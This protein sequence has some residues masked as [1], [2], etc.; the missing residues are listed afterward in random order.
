MV[1]IMD[2]FKNRKWFGGAL[3]AIIA[4][5]SIS[6]MPDVAYSATADEEARS[7]IN[8]IV[9]A[10]IRIDPSDNPEYAHMWFKQI[11]GE[12]IFAPWS[13]SIKKNDVT[14]LS[15]AVGF[16][17]ILA[18]ILGVVIVYYVMIGGAL[19]TAHHGEVLGK[20]WSSVWIPIRTATGFFLIMPVALGGKVLSF[21]Q[22]F[23]IW[24]IM[25][26]SNSATLLWNKTIDSILNGDPISSPNI[27]VGMQP[28]A[29]VAKMLMCTELYIRN[30]TIGKYDVDTNS[31][32]LIVAT[33]YKGYVGDHLRSESKNMEVGAY[34]IGNVNIAGALK[35]PAVQKISFAD[36]GDCGSISFA[37]KG[38]E[39]DFATSDETD[40]DYKTKAMM[41]GYQAARERTASLIDKLQPLI[42]RIGAN[43]DITALYN[44]RQEELSTSELY[45]SYQLEAARFK[46]ISNQFSKNIVNDIHSK[47]SGNP[48]MKN[49]WK[50][51][52]A[53]GGWGK[54][55]LWFFELGAIPGMTYSVYN[56]YIGSIKSGNPTMC[57]SIA[58]FFGDSEECARKNAE[59][60]HAYSNIDGFIS[61]SMRNHTSGSSSTMSAEDR[62]N[63]SSNM[64]EE[65]KIRA[66]DDPSKC[67]LNSDTMNSMTDSFSMDILK[68]L[69]EKNNIGN[70]SSMASPFQTVASIGHSLNVFTTV[71][72][73][74]GMVSNGMLESAQAAKNS[75][76]GKAA[77]V[78]TASTGSASLGFAR[79]S[80]KWML[81][82]IIALATSLAATGFI[83]AYMIPFL[84]IITW[85]MMVT[86]YLITAVEAVIAAPLAVI[87]MVT[88]EGEGIAG[89]RL[90]RAMQL[91]AM[92][93][94]KPSLMIIGLIASI[95]ISGVSFAIMNEFFFVAAKHVLTGGPFDFIAVVMLYTTLA[96]QL[97]KMLISI[98][99]KLPEQ[100]LEWFSSGVGRSFG[101]NEVGGQ[102]ES[103]SGEMKS[104]LGGMGSSLASD[105]KADRRHK[106][107][108]KGAKAQ[109]PPDEGK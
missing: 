92:A 104:A 7:A 82:S 75:W 87:M 45:K 69:S 79:G 22:I 85:I 72:W 83:L 12:F 19:N 35:D 97:C 48:A 53:S 49:A 107:G 70:T 39:G 58:G 31:D 61:Y 67:G 51:N 3:F 93:I 60:T 73:T 63:I 6:L 101:E 44:A 27:V 50:N 11:F 41:D 96:F 88:P 2:F 71:T 20:E 62:E 10:P 8:S 77:D 13:D 14:L 54:A 36:G 90:E 74:V 15:R 37:D 18:M 26:G 42:N 52:M 95:T 56:D 108:N 46:G 81:M 16:T 40:N 76:L 23:I 94:L 89:T 29:N 38:V 65:D 102:I 68:L 17:N 103:G 86:G 78:L 98:M 91:L 109:T 25:I 32:D 64:S 57:S 21:A 99:H 28:A 9:S 43:N 55:G 33:V 30:E 5:F 84:P 105:Q 47:V 106:A 66:C 1:Y 59:F 80:V 24:L 34:G 100:I 4:L